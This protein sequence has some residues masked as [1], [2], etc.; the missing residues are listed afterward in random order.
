[1]KLSDMTT[2]PARAGAA[3]LRFF[4]GAMFPSLEGTTITLPDHGREEFF[5]L[6]RGRQFLFVLDRMHEE[7]W[8]GGTD[9][10]PFL[11][12]LNWQAFE[13]F[14]QGGARAF[15]QDFVPH[16]IKE[17]RRHFPHLKP[18][19]QG[20]VWAFP[21]PF[22]WDELKQIGRFEDGLG[23]LQGF[24]RGGRQKVKDRSVLGTRHTLQ[25]VVSPCFFIIG[26]HVDHDVVEGVLTAPSHSPL[27]L[28]GPHVLFRSP[29]VRID[30]RNAGDD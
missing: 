17:L 12:K 1:M 27:R 24:E 11:T 2:K 5:P 7:V 23:D 21:V 28:R 20:D 26:G 9:D 29:A 4:P 15:Y 30:R 13:T 3:V 25:G 16:Q 10:S 14:E 8:F 22:S 6:K 18:L 19:R